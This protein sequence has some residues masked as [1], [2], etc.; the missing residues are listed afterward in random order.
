MVVAAIL[1]IRCSLSI[2]SLGN[3][4]STQQ[5]WSSSDLYN[6][7]T[8][9]PAKTSKGCDHRTSSHSSISN[10]SHKAAATTSAAAAKSSSNSSN[11][12][13]IN[14]TR[15]VFL[16]PG[17]QRVASEPVWRFVLQVLSRNDVFKEAKAAKMEGLLAWKELHATLVQESSSSLSS[18]QQQKNSNLTTDA[19]QFVDNN[20]NDCPFAISNQNVTALKAA[21]GGGSEVYIPCGLVVESSISFLGTPQ[22]YTG[23]FTIELLLGP[24]KRLLATAQQQ[25]L[26]T[27]P[28][29]IVLHY[30]VRMRGDKLTNNPVIVQ[31]TWTSDTEWN[32]E[33][34]CPP[35][36]LAPIKIVDNLESCSSKVGENVI[37]SQESGE[38]TT[39]ASNSISGGR[40]KSKLW[41]PFAE[42]IPFAATLWM[43]AEGF[44]MTVNGRHISSFQYRQGLEPWLVNRVL[45]RGD[46]KPSSVV[47]TGL[48]ATED[49]MFAPDLEAIRALP[50]SGS[51][52]LF[53]GVISSSNNYARRM[54][55]RRT[56]LQYPSV[57]NRTVAV[58]FFVGLQ[59]NKQVN[60]ELWKEALTYG[61]MQ[62]LPFVDYYELIVF[63][64]LAICMFAT[65]GVKAKYMMKTD[66]DTFVRVDA[67]L[68]AIRKTNHTRSLLLGYIEFTSEPNRDTES[69]WYVDYEEWSYMRY[70]PWAHGPGY[71]IS[72]DVAKFVVEG[73]QKLLLK[74]FKLEDVAMGMWIQKYK[75]WKP[76]QVDYISNDLFVHMGC[77]ADYVIAHYQNP[78][79]MQCLWQL[80]M[81][82]DFTHCCETVDI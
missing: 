15:S 44:H 77:E 49:T 63:K 65:K 26:Q 13:S 6:N 28:P 23:E 20:K 38:S 22:G 50:L 40:D 46:V 78:G 31:N 58:R 74:F 51:V 37:L 1:L 9:A 42:G 66:D 54:A 56:W 75:K 79:Q 48:P 60:K 7:I 25:Q 10:C 53:I 2:G 33:E 82:Q 17:S 73:H 57:R 70:P 80:A 62:L 39:T 81:K 27:D 8:A 4:Y 11:P 43:G 12:K 35:P 71:I 61:D 14:I 52:E 67:V 29:P 5:I 72:R 18:S 19:K 36:L 16:L 45:I 30:T 64:T 69:K 47:M 55:V 34:R 68:S 32:D 76:K 21:A 59:Q 24:P 3:Y 41:F